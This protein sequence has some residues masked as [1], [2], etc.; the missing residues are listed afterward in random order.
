[1]LRRT[2]FMTFVAALLASASLSAGAQFA[3]DCAAIAET[4]PKAGDGEYLISPGGKTFSV[5]CYDMAG[6][7]REYLTL[8]NTG[9]S[10]NYS[11]HGFVGGPN[12]PVTTHY[13]R[14]RIDP[15][16]LLVNI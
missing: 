1:M 16:P 3:P 5:Y 13:T 14:I 10:Y 12:A 15:A 7:P 6:T 9:G 2:R 4:N 11:L 8:A